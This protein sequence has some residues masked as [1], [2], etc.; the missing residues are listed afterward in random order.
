MWAHRGVLAC[1]QSRDAAKLW[2]RL[3]DGDAN[4]LGGCADATGL[5]RVRDVAS[6]NGSSTAAV[7]ERVRK[8]EFV[9]YRIQ[10][11]RKHGIGGS[12]PH[13]RARQ[14]HRS[15]PTCP[16]H[17]EKQHNETVSDR[18][19]DRAAAMYSLIITAKLNDTDPRAWLA[20]VLRQINDHPASRL[21]ELLPWNWRKPAQDIAAVA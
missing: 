21:H 12:P 7:W 11:G 8:G 5:E 13:T 10:Q 20:D 19:G 18:G 9:A 2:I 1:D 6:R 3:E 4:R 15:P 14:R 17:K 16:Q